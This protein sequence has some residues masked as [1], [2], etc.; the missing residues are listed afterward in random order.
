MRWFLGIPF[1]SSLGFDKCKQ[2]VAA[3][4]QNLVCERRYDE[5]NLIFFIPMTLCLE[6]IGVAK[7][8]FMIM[9][10]IVTKIHNVTILMI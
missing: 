4:G 7:L 9:I 3:V 6:I 5:C 10:I 2:V 8:L 1:E